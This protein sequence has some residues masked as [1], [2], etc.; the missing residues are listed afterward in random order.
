MIRNVLL[1]WSGTLADDLG[2]V[3]EASNRVFAHYGA[4]E[5]TRHRF[6]E[7]F[8]LPFVEFYDRTLPG[9]PIKEL[10]DLYHVHFDP[11]Q[12]RVELLPFARELLDFL[13]ATGRRAFLLSS[14]R[15]AHWIKQ[16]ERLGVRHCFEHPYTGVMDKSALIHQIIEERGLVPAETIFVG[17]MMHDIATAVHGGIQGIAVTTGYDSVEKLTLAGAP[18]IISNLRELISLIDERP[19]AAE[20]RLPPLPSTAK[21]LP[22]PTVGALMFKGDGRFL[23][24]HTKKWSGTWGIPGGKIRRGESQFAALEREIMEETAL[25][26]RQI[27]FVM[28]QDCINSAEFERPEHFLLLNFTAQ[29]NAPPESVRLNDEASD[30]AWV[31]LPE[32][33]EYPLNQPTKILLA[34]LVKQG[35]L[36]GS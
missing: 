7:E 12:D 15:P 14:I 28:V 23:L 25:P 32:A 26:I 2:P 31:T 6:Q 13:A 3:L 27:E 30:F 4:P 17:D 1:D 9:I 34:E 19:D 35:K 18:V 5:F 22:V 20:R 16:A 8:C 33:L 21:P 29:T 24:V 10:D 11:I 36:A